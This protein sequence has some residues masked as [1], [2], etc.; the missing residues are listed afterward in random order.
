[1]SYS[2]KGNPD[3]GYGET[4]SF[5]SM[6]AAVEGEQEQLIQLGTP[7]AMGQEQRVL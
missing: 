3:T 7:P 4:N 1:M 6:I 2:S 5:L